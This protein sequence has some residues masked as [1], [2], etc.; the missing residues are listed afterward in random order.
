[1]ITR[2]GI[3]TSDIEATLPA[4]IAYL[5]A[6]LRDVDEPLTM[7]QRVRPHP[8]IAKLA[9]EDQSRP[10]PIEFRRRRFLNFLFAEVEQRGGK[11]T[12][13]E[14]HEFKVTVAGEPLNVTV[15][16]PW[17]DEARTAN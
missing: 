7:P 5:I 8:L 1:M 11:V 17:E 14:R 4:D 3:R 16:E 6:T 12:S 10:K 15:R 9:L 2:S 13:G